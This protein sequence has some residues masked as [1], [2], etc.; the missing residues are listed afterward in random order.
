MEPE[1]HGLIL[2]ISL[3][4]GVALIFAGMIEKSIE[5]V[6]C[7]LVL[8]VIAKIASKKGWKR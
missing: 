7:G 4:L 2:F 8:S 6:I 3:L 1:W 5:F